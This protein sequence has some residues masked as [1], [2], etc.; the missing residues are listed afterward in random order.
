MKRRKYGWFLVNYE[1]I[2]NHN[3]SKITMKKVFGTFAMSALLMPMV[4]MTSCKEN[5]DERFE[6]EAR[7]YTEKK[8]PVMIYENTRLDSMTYDRKTRTISHYHT[9]SGSADNTT[10]TKYNNAHSAMVDAVKN[11]TS[12]KTPKDEGCSFRYVF[13]SASRPEVIIEDITVT[14]KDY[15]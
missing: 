3:Q 11:S 15:Q 6:R 5:I 4:A 10:G 7:E 14:P 9:L 13:R 1:Y 12:L 2:C 8:C